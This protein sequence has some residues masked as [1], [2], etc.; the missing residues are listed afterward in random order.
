VADGLGAIRFP[1]TN[2]NRT[3]QNNLGN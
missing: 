1:D 3:E 2:M